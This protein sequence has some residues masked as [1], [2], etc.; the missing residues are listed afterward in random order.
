[1]DTIFLSSAVMF[2]LLVLFRISFCKSPNML[3]LS[4]NPF[5]TKKR[6]PKILLH[7]PLLPAWRQ[8]FAMVYRASWGPC[9]NHPFFRSWASSLQDS[10]GSLKYSS[11]WK[12]KKTTT[13]RTEIQQRWIP[14]PL[15]CRNAFSLLCP[16][17]KQEEAQNDVGAYYVVLYLM[18]G[19]TRKMREFF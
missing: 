1:M 8:P 18:R 13:E 9:L 6:K 5:L 12:K 15:Y 14:L 10:K 7:N 11:H 3:S 4:T 16:A 2:L 19:H 17:H